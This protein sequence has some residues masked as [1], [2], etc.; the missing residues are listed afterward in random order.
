MYL[1][2]QD[3]FNPMDLHTPVALDRGRRSARALA[4]LLLHEKVVA[5]S[6]PD[7]RT[8]ELARLVR[9]IRQHPEHDWSREEMARR[10]HVSV[11]QLTRLFEIH[12]GRPPRE[13]VIRQRLNRAAEDLISTDDTIETIALRNGYGS[14]Y[15]F[16][17]Q[18]KKHIG[19]PPGKYRSLFGP[20]TG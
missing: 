5:G 7:H 9:T 18:F 1:L 17:S 15:S 2:L 20:N 6:N 12:Y 16:S 4:N 3:L 14:I 13:L 8:R 11:R 19:M 10:L